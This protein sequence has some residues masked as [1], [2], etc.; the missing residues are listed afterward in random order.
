VTGLLTNGVNIIEGVD[1]RTTSLRKYRDEARAMAVRAA[2]EKAKAMTDEL[3]VKLGRPCNVNANDSSYY[4]GG[5]NRSFNG[6]FNANNYVQNVSSAVGGGAT[7][8]NASDTFAVGQIS[9]TATVNISFLI[10]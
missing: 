5:W 9:V 4:W 8:D 1:F 6:G 2:K 3:G 10:E 7:S